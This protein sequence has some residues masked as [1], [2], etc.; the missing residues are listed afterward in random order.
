MYDDPIEREEVIQKSIT[1][2]KSKVDK[3]KS[4]IESVKY[5]I[6][7]KKKEKATM[8]T[9]INSIEEEIDNIRKNTKDLKTRDLHKW[10]K[11]CG[12][13]RD[14]DKLLQTDVIRLQEDENSARNLHEIAWNNLHSKTFLRPFLDSITGMEKIFKYVMENHEEVCIIL[15]L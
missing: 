8:E 12:R 5:Q 1:D 2:L 15:P 4:N 3:L 7:N 13:L 11:E 9:K 10:Q 6:E 14:E